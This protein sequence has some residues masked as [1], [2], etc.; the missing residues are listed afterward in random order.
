VSADGQFVVF[1]SDSGNFAPET[2]SPF[3]DEDIFVRDR[4]AG[5]T[6]RVSE[7]SAGEEGNARSLGPAISADGSITTF[8]SDA[9]NLVPN[10]NNFVKDIFVHDERPAA[11][12][13]VTKSDSPDP[14]TKGAALTYSV[15]VTN[16]GPGSATALQLTDQLST[17]VRFESVTSTAGSCSEADGIVTC[18]LGDI[19][20]GATVTVMINVT[21]RRTG[22]ATNT[23]QVSSISPDS[24][25]ANNADT[26]ETVITR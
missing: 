9:S 12:I 13:A 17:S 8:G 6:V 21:A 24:N 14:V 11:D 4:L 16:Q 20:N 26:E 23:A 22:T 25:P 3:P 10:D 18:S 15:V 19:P 7:S 1:Q 5:T 2:S